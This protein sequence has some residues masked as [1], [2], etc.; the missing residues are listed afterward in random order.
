MIRAIVI[1]LVAFLGNPGAKFA[2]NRHNAGWLLAEKSPFLTGVSWQRKFKGDYAR[3][4]RSVIA[5]GSAGNN[6]VHFLKPET[7]MNLSGDAVA[8]AAAFFKIPAKNTLIVHDELD[9]LPGQAGFKFSGGL[10]GHNGL[11]SVKGAFGTADFWRLRIGI[12]RPSDNGDEGA[13]YRWVLGDFSAAETPL[14]ET[15]LAACA[16]ALEN[17]LVHGAESLLPEW[18]KKTVERALP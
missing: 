12:G 5:G 3:V 11:R 10:N 17:A 4:E 8:A 7:Y 16:E 14:L 1:E 9:L 13:V 18:A 2:R 15:T 6:T